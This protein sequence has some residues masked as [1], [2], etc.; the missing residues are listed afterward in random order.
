MRNH[1]VESLGVTY[2]VTNWPESIAEFDQLAKREGACLDEACANIQYRGTNPKFREPF[3]ELVEKDTGIA[4]KVRTATLKDGTVKEYWDE[5]EGKYWNRVLAETKRAA[6]SFQG[7]ADQVS[8]EFDPSV[9]V[10]ESAG[11]KTAPKAYITA[12]EALLK[13]GGAK[14]AAA[15]AKIKQVLGRDANISDAKEFAKD[16]KAWKVATTPKAPPIADELSA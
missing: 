13:E 5:S 9:K 2:T 16:I 15:Q 12:A 6:E 11:P 3:L 10:T 1:K 8:V 14:L 4:R 7:L